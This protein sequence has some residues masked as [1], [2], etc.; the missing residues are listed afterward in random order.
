MDNHR[1]CFVCG[2]IL[3][4]DRDEQISENSNYLGGTCWTSY[5]AWCS[6]VFDGLVDEFLKLEIVICDSCLRKKINTAYGWENITEYKDEPLD[7]G[8][9]FPEMKG[10][11]KKIPIV[12]NHKLGKFKKYD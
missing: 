7:L 10:K 6:S 5:G 3:E 12:K 4:L 1:E 2:K 8:E 9:L 11:N